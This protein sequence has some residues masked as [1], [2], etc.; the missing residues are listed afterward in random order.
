MKI[1]FFDSGIGGLSVLKEAMQLLPYED[2]IYYA[3]SENAPYGT[4]SEKVIEQLVFKAVDFLAKYELKALVIACNTATSVVIKKLRAKYDFPIIG[5]EP[6][7]KPAIEHSSDKKSLICATDL[8]L[9]AAK[10]QE[11]IHSL[12]AIDRIEKQTLQDLVMYAEQFDFDG[13]KVKTYLKK[14]F[15]GIDW[16][17]FDSIILGCTHFLFFKKQI[18]EAIP[19][20]IQLLDGNLGTVRH[21]KNNIKI[22]SYR[23]TKPIEYYISG[24][25][26]SAE[27]FE[28]YFSH[29]QHNIIPTISFHPFPKLKTPRLLLRKLLFKDAKAL[30]PILSDVENRQYIDVP[31][32]TKLKEIHAYID[33]RKSGVK[34]NDWIFWAI[35]LK[36]QADL[37]G[38]I[39]LWNFSKMKDEAE[40]GFELSRSHQGKGIMQEAVT[41]VLEY[42]FVDLHLVCIKATTHIDNQASIRLLE[43]N[44][45][46]PQGNILVE[47]SSGTH[48]FEMATF[49]LH[50]N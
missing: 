10:L 43:R 6:A 20:S 37:I 42:G 46:I 40:I 12:K 16:S 3:D 48:T 50:K 41:K 24:K 19:D 25:K 23:K 39:C 1:A 21:L 38:T 33:F 28:K 15:Q 8:T 49:S 7:I 26:E 11:L 29:L 32:V 31:N 45:F 34:R 13:P 30:Q 2:Y 27:N 18:W 4:K 35:N 14:Q 5:M 47:H 17:E 9:R 22:S 36:G 44:H